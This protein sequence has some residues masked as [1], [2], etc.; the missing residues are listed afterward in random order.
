MWFIYPHLPSR[1]TATSR[2]GASGTGDG[3][4]ADARLARAVGGLRANTHDRARGRI[5]EVGWRI[6]LIACLADRDGP[7]LDAGPPERSSRAAR[8]KRTGARPRSPCLGVRQACSHTP[9]PS[10]LA[11]PRHLHKPRSQSPEARERRPSRVHGAPLAASVGWQRNALQ[12]LVCR[13]AA[14]PE[15]VRASPQRSLVTRKEVASLTG[16]NSDRENATCVSVLG[17]PRF[18]GHALEAFSAGQ[19]RCGRAAA[20]LALLQGGLFVL[21]LDRGKANNEC[22][23]R[24]QASGQDMGKETQRHIAPAMM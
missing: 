3:L 16:S 6:P 4:P 9:R 1:T 20:A 11:R 21:A 12:L 22:R 19:V 10:A 13:V 18:G 14:T 7:H 5:D 8:T 23:S 24:N 17:A 2:E 15:V